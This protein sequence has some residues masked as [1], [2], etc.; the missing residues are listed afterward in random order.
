[1]TLTTIE[2]NLLK[3]ASKIIGRKLKEKDLLEWSSSEEIVRNNLQDGEQIIK[4][5]DLG[6]WIAI[7]KG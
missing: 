1:M 4:L 3:E 6:F 5:S 7:P 2:R